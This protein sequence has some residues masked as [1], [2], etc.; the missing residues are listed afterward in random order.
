MAVV[1]R[2]GDC[3]SPGIGVK[4]G[5]MERQQKRALRVVNQQLKKIAMLYRRWRYIKNQKEFLEQLEKL[6]S[7]TQ[8]R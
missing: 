8:D 2:P 4:F 5:P 1:G 6:Q 7:P 3:A